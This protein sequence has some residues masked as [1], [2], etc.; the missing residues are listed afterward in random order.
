MCFCNAIITAS[1]GLEPPPPSGRER[2]HSEQRHEALLTAIAELNKGGD[3][4]RLLVRVE[5]RRLF[6]L[7]STVVV[8][9]LGLVVSILSSTGF[10]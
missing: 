6:L 1:T 5:Q 9:L 8:L 4:V 10:L 2:S 7:V 3:P